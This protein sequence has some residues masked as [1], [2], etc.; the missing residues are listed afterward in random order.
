ML[1][2]Q[3]L[4]DVNPQKTIATPFHLQRSGDVMHHFGLLA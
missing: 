3:P 4:I 1:S 2:Q